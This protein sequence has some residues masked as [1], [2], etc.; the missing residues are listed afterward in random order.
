VVT[1]APYGRSDP[2]T[3]RGRTVFRRL[4]DSAAH[5]IGYE[6]HGEVTEQ[7]VERIQADIR[8]AIEDHGRIRLLVTLDDLQ[9]VEPAAVWQDLKMTDEYAR[10]LD[11]MAVVGSERWQEWVT[12]AADV[13]TDAAYFGPEEHEAAWAWLREGAARSSEAA[14]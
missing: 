4:P 3:T 9:G 5:V 11:R 1:T 8:S 7:D 10:H 2:T 6:L 14:G 12:R 13:M